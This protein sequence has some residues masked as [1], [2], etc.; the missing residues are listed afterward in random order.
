MTVAMPAIRGLCWVSFLTKLSL[1]RSKNS[2]WRSYC[3]IAYLPERDNFPENARLKPLTAV[4]HVVLMT[5]LS[6]TTPALLWASESTDFE[7][8]PVLQVEIKGSRLHVYGERLLS[9]PDDRVFFGNE[10]AD[11]LLEPR[12]LDANDSRIQLMLPVRPI[13]GRYK[14]KIGE[15]EI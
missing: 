5:V 10:D 9:I 15:T 14:L 2:F 3:T 4:K 1:R 13:S 12:L 8:G 7:G 11:Y 6:V